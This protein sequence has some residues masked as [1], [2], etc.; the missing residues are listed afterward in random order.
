[1]IRE[2]IQPLGKRVVTVVTLENQTNLFALKD[3]LEQ[4]EIA[5][6]LV[7]VPSEQ[8]VLRSGKP[9][10]DKQQTM[11]IYTDSENNTNRLHTTLAEMNLCE[12]SFSLP[13]RDAPKSLTA[14]LQIGS[15]KIV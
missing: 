1:M 2:I 4:K 14:H 11:I 15:L 12:A 5:R 3:I 10:I 7:I 13:L 8:I 6:R 9:K